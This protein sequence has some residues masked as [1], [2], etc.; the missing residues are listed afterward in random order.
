MFA[1]GLSLLLLLSTSAFAS[2]QYAELVAETEMLTE[3][4]NANPENGNQIL[5]DNIE[6][7]TAILAKRGGKNRGS[8]DESTQDDAG[9]LA[10]RDAIKEFITVSTGQEFLLLPPAVSPVPFDT[11]ENTRPG[12][13]NQLSLV[14]PGVLFGNSGTYLVMYSMA[15]NY[16]NSNSLIPTPNIALYPSISPPN[17]LSGG[18]GVVGPINEVTINSAGFVLPDLSGSGINN[19]FI[20]DFSDG[21]VLELLLNNSSPTDNI[22]ALPG[23]FQYGVA[24]PIFSMTII[25]LY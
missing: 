4:M 5:V 19:S 18:Q 16:K 21:D 11:V 25:R 20:A 1:T 23:G 14:G 12:S 3:L 9:P 24:G 2:D 7:F 6:E 13:S 10:K 22:I 8:Q 15:G 17:A